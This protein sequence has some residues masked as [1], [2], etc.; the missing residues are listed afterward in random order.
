MEPPCAPYETAFADGRIG[1]Y[2]CPCG[3]LDCGVLSTRIELTPSR[4]TWHDVGWQVTYRPF[5]PEQELGVVRFDFDRVQY[6]E[7]FQWLMAADWSQ[8]VPAPVA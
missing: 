4:V 3:D 8:G 7:L 2:F 1:L 6:D 5:D